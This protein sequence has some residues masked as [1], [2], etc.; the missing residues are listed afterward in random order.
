MSQ[1]SMIVL[2]TRT[3]VVTIIHSMTLIC[4]RPKAG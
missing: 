2:D 1:E 4:V 3:A